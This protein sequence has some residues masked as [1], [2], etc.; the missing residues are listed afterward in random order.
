MAR[1]GP[2]TETMVVRL[3]QIGVFL[4]STTEN[5]GV[6]GGDWASLVIKG[7]SKDIKFLHIVT[8]GFHT[9]ENSIRKKELY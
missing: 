9:L 5:V 2:I 7:G 8:L 6:G 4:G 1:A 3:L